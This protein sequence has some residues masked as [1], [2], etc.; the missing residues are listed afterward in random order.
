MFWLASPGSCATSGA[1][2]AF[3]S[4]GTIRTETGGR[5]DA[6][7][8]QLETVIRI[9]WMD[10]GHLLN[11]NTCPPWCHFSY[12]FFPAPPP[13]YI[14]TLFIS[15]SFPNSF[16]M[17]IEQSVSVFSGIV[18]YWA[19]ILHLA[20]LYS[21]LGHAYTPL[22]CPFYVLLNFIVVVVVLVTSHF[23]TCCCICFFGLYLFRR[24]ISPRFGN[25]FW[26]VEWANK[27][28]SSLL[29]W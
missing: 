22:L 28:L 12:P 20:I 19:I 27:H 17:Y 14:W 4:S 25:K 8:A 18:C 29:C 21:F 6:Q 15:L 24:F 23:N 3:L 26:N 9:G 13:S 10:I 16:S 7:I 1:K 2:V 5:T 11:N